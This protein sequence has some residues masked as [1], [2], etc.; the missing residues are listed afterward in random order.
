MLLCAV[1]VLACA[2]L[3]A[4]L[5]RAR[6][7]VEALRYRAEAAELMDDAAGREINRLRARL[8]T[9]EVA[10]MRPSA[11]CAGHDRA[12]RAE[13]APTCPACAYLSIGVEVARHLR[14]PATEIRGPIAPTEAPRA[15]I[16]R[17]GQA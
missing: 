5:W 9:A 1:L 3:G 13:L 15:F 10:A 6:R 2:C 12:R 4:A 17:R 16:I 7:T 8:R 11:A 14:V